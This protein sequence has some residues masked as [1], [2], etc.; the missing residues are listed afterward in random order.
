MRKHSVP[1][2]LHYFTSGIWLING[3]FCK[4]M[5][6]VPRHQEIVATILGYEHARIITLLIGLAEIG[7]AVWILTGI[8]KELNGIIQII[9]VTVMNCLEFFLAPDLLLWGKANAFFALVFIVLIYYN[10]FYISKKLIQPV[11]CKNF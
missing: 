10:A 5:N 3:L 6:L 8:R 11:T 1:G 7:M 4:V 9:V 2:W